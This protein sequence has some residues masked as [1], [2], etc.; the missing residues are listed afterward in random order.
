MTVSNIDGYLWAEPGTWFIDEK[1]TLHV[2]ETHDSE[3]VP[4]TPERDDTPVHTSICGLDDGW[5][6]VSFGYSRGDF[7]FVSEEQ[8]KDKPEINKC[9]ICFSE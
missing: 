8:V 4:F 6:S 9:P 7:N 1:N 5:R 2:V 3:P